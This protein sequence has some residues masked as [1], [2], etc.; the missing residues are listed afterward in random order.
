MQRNTPLMRVMYK[1]LTG[2]FHIQ[3]LHVS[4]LDSSMGKKPKTCVITHAFHL[5]PGL[6]KPSCIKGPTGGYFSPG[7]VRGRGR[8]RGWAR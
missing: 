1:T 2:M 8:G 6:T 3:F 5:K 7:L 4:L